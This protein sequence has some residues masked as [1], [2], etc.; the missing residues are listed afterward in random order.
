MLGGAAGGAIAVKTGGI[1]SAAVPM[2]SIAG[3]VGGSLLADQIF[4]NPFEGAATGDSGIQAK[5][6]MTQDG[7]RME[8][9]KPQGVPVIPG[10]KTNDMLVRDLKRI[11]ETGVREGTGTSGAGGSKKAMVN[12]PVTIDLGPKLGGKFTHEVRQEI[13]LALSAL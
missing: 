13:E 3:G 10:V 12:I 1:G 4:G 5:P 2:M 6:L 11:V 7:G 9:A 8:I